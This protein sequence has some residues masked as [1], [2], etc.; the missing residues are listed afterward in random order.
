MRRAA[1]IFA[2]VVLTASTGG[3]LGGQRRGGAKR[4]GESCY[5]AKDLVVQ[6]LERLR[7]DS[8][9]NDLGDANQLLKRA[10]DMCAESGDAWYFRALVEAK[11]NQPP[12]AEYAIGQARDFGS[13]ALK[14]GLNPFI[15]C[16]A[17]IAWI[18]SGGI[19]EKTAAEGSARARDSR[20]CREQVGA[21]DWHQPV[22][23]QGNPYAELLHTGC[24]CFFSRAE[25]SRD[26]TVSGGECEGD[27]QR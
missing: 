13:E 16:H 9:P 14:Q 25:G 3:A 6:A 11:L 18:Q 5:T 21:G 20:A 15:L 17:G 19:G 4:A 12:K 23:R 27:Y 7:A 22:Y 1:V 24:R 2:L 26:R 8:G 10:I